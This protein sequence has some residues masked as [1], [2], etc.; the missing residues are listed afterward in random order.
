MGLEINFVC[1]IY[2]IFNNLKILSIEASLIY[3]LVQ[4]LVSVLL[5]FIFLIYLIN[6]NLIFIYFEYFNYFIL[7]LIIIKLGGAPLHFWFPLVING[8][9]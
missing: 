8:L 1:F 2:L 9:N 4:S 6:I 3:F 7:I 5:L